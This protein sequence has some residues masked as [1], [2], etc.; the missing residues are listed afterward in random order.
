M[1]INCH[2]FNILYTNM[3]HPIYA[4]MTIFAKNIYM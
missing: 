3:L 2:I 4:D 1:G